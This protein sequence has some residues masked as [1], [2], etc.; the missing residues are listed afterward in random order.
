M[1]FTHLQQVGR[2]AAIDRPRSAT[3]KFDEPSLARRY[4]RFA[5]G[6]SGG[7]YETSKMEIGVQVFRD[8]GLAAG[9]GGSVN[10]SENIC[11]FEELGTLQR[12]LF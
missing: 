4:F 1:I 5:R 8:G 2:L 12:R 9:C 10:T 7:L 11:R 3:I 6:G